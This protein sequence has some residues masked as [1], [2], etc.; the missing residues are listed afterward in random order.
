MASALRARTTFN[1]RLT[2]ASDIAGTSE[3]AKA[4]VKTLGKVS[5]VKAE[6]PS[7]PNKVTASRAEYPAT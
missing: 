2:V 5:S 1:W 3:V 7:C 6:P 4:N